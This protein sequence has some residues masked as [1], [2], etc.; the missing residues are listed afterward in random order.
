MSLNSSS[1]NQSKQS[2]S[3]SFPCLTNWEMKLS[4]SSGQDI[5]YYYYY[6]DILLRHLKNL[7]PNV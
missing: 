4:F 7:S 3:K 6:L 1:L 2:K 5:N